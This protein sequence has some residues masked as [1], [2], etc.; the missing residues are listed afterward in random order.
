MNNIDL[1]WFM[2]RDGLWSCRIRFAGR[3]DGILVHTEDTELEC[4]IRYSATEIATLV[5]EE[6]A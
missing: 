3:E 4:A 1:A 2:T 6:S 5:E